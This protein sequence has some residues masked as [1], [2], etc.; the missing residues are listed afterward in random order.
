MYQGPH[1][2]HIDHFELIK[3]YGAITVHVFVDL[4]QYAEQSHIGLPSTLKWRTERYIL[5]ETS[6][7]CDYSGTPLNRHFSTADTC[8]ITNNFEC[9]DCISIYSNP[10]NTGQSAIPHNRYLFWSYLSLR[11]SEQPCITDS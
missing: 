9:L 2:S 5:A 11:N 8:D 6:Y 10:L 7:I 1:R 4:P 3:V